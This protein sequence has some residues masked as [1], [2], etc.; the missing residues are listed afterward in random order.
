MRRRLRSRYAL[1]I[2]GADRTTTTTLV[3]KLR[4]FRLTCCGCVECGVRLEE[5]GAT[6]EEK[7]LVFQISEPWW[8]VLLSVFAVFGA[9]PRSRH[10]YIFLCG[11]RACVAENEAGGGQSR[12]PEISADSVPQEELLFLVVV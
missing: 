7:R 2:G 5:C 10:H 11:T 1:G 3:Q 8:C 12:I 4:F 6:T 9:P